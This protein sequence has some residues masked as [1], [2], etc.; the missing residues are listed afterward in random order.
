MLSFIKGIFADAPASDRRPEPGFSVP[1]SSRPTRAEWRLIG[2]LQAFFLVTALFGLNGPFVST[3]FVR[4]NYTF[5]VAQHVFH[6]GWS[7]VITPRGSFTQL[8]T[9][10]NVFSPLP[11]PAPRYTICH[12]EVPF[13]GLIGWPAANVFQ[14]DERAVV[15]LVAMMFT[16][17]SIRFLYLVLRYWL[18]PHPALLGTAVWT[19]APLI[20]HFGQVPMPDILATTGMAAA[21][22]FALRGR[23]V[24]CSGA[25]LFAILAKMSILIYGLPI[26]VA[27]L[28]ARDARSAGACVKLSLLWG[29]VP[30]LGLLGWLSLSLHDPPGSWGVVRG[31]QPGGYGPVRLTDLAKPEFYVRPLIFLFPFGCGLLGFLGLL[32]AAGSATPRMNP[33]LKASILISLATNYVMERIVCWEPQYTLPVLFWVM[34]AASLGF[35]RLLEKLRGNN[36]RKIA[37]AGI[38]FIQVVVVIGAAWF[39]KASRV[40]NL[41]DMEAAMKLIPANARVVIYSSVTSQPPPVWLNRNTLSFDPFVDP[42]PADFNILE[43]QL[44]NF[45]KAGFD[46]LLLLDVQERY[47]FEAIIARGSRYQTDF[48]NHSSPERHF[49]DQ[50]FH[51]MFEGNHVVLYSLAQ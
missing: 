41:P 43:K 47:K 9:P 17:L 7:A 11:V 34:I 29:I 33:W 23:L 6:E 51:E 39:L 19:T 40:P 46:Y 31:F 1:G 48:T 26:L 24:A 44:R 5:D 15:R 12:L 4:Q 20:L 18:D 13:F 36:R 37:A 45:Q 49:F 21:F 8:S 42:K 14:H 50:K 27:L 16:L 2:I 28:I 10:S 35:P 32:F 3:H 38:F 22:F 30:L 25:F